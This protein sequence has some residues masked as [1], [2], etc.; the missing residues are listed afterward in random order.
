M[1]V[2]DPVYQRGV[3]F[4]LRTQFEDGSWWVRSRTWPFQ[5]HFNGQ[6]PHGKDQ[7]ISQGATAW[8]A[9]ALLLTLD[10]VQPAP[11]V[12]NAQALMAM[13]AKSPAARRKK[14][15]TAT[16]SSAVATA[17]VD[18]ARDIQPLFKRSCAGC[19]GGEK[20]RGG[21]AFVSRE[22]LLK[23]GAS[24]EPAITPGYADDSTMI[25]YVTGTIEDL[26]MPPLD[27]R[28]KYPALS[29]AEIELLRT[30]IDSGAAWTPAKPTASLAP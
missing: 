15:D 8:A 18:F 10:P 20:P 12:P 5:P 22:A 27:R 25:H 16:A 21:L 30:W 28:E 24:G 13:Y 29:P 26:E 11:V 9:M 6:F 17:T 4:L 7:W 19:H 23:G 3:A 14:E 2:T 1:P